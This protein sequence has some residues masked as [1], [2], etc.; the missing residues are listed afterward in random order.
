MPRIRP[1]LVP[2]VVTATA[3][4]IVIAGVVAWRMTS[5]PAFGAVPKGH[6][7]PPTHR[8]VYHPGP[9]HR[10]HPLR[11]EVLWAASF[12]LTLVAIGTTVRQRHQP[13]AAQIVSG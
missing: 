2:A 8:Q 9:P 11:A 6:Y 3:L 1:W 4:V 12:F 5:W 13:G 10:Q 7:L